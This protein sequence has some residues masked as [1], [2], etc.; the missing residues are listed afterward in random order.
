MADRYQALV[1]FAHDLALSEI[2]IRFF[3]K[4][5]GLR[6]IDGTYGVRSL[7]QKSTD[8]LDRKYNDPEAAREMAS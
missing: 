4:N 1:L 5:L 6:E 7:H 8:D 2:N 3:L